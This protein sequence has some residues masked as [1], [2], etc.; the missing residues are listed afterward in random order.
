MRVVIQRVAEAS[1]TVADKIVGQIGVGLCVFLGVGAL[2]DETNGSYLADKIINLRIFE[3]EQGK[4]NRSVIDVRGEILVVS[5]F[6]LYGEAK[7]G[8]RPS[9]S[10]AA[11][12][13]QAQRLYDDF[14]HRLQ[15][16]GLRIASGQFQAQM[17]VSLTNDGPVTL[18]LESP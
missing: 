5:Q 18:I 14:I 11:P 4:M 1:V 12:P 15:T 13:A 6:T 8:N 9:F 16:S 3:D 7:K 17:A 2:D 10:G